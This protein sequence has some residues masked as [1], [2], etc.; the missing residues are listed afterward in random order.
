MI[1]FVRKRKLCSSTASHLTAAERRGKYLELLERTQDGDTS[2]HLVDAD[3]LTKQARK[4]LQKAPDAN[5]I[6]ISQNDNYNY[7]QSEEEMKII[8]EEGTP[9]GALFRA[10]NVIASNLKDEFPN[11]AFDTL[12]YQWSRPAPKITKPK[13]NV[14]IRLCD[15]ECNFAAPLTDPSNAPFQKD[16]NAW[17]AISVRNTHIF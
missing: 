13:P 8:N 11:I 5:I 1:F 3:Y 7:C 2:L 6:S 15:I 10:I 14:I 9:G 12:A 16:M 4:T 17:A